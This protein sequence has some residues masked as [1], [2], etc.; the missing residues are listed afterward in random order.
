[1]KEHE[2]ERE[3]KFGKGKNV[4]NFW[5]VIEGSLFRS[6]AWH[7]G[8]VF[9]C[10]AGVFLFLF[11]FVFLLARFLGIFFE[12]GV[13]A[14]IEQTERQIGKEGRKEDKQKWN[15][16]IRD[17]IGLREFNQPIDLSTAMV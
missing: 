7:F 2:R 6:G 17:G 15:T 12:Q 9:S 8:G 11:L 10:F 13:L 16:V 4:Y 14:Y 5:R 1:M 3:L